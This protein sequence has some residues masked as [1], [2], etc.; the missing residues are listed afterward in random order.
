LNATIIAGIILS[1]LTAI[2][3][4]LPLLGVAANAS[5]AVANIITALTK[6]VPVLE[7]LAPIVGNEIT[8]LYQ[9]IK[10]IIANLRGTSIETTA[11]QDADLDALDSQVDASW[12]AISAQFDPDAVQATP[13]APT[14]PPATS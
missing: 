5:T 8:L 7:Q 10:N 14:T 6:I 3:S 12:N 9:G 13:A 11:Q 1:T 4:L 2:Q